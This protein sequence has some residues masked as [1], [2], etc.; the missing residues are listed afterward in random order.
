MQN[1]K[2]YIT[3]CPRDAMQGIT[4]FIPTESKIAYLNKLMEVGFDRLDFGSFVSPKAI[5]QLR[6]TVEVLS[7]LNTNSNTKLLAIVANSRGAEDASKFET[8]RYLGFPFSVSETFQK[9][10]TNTS[11]TESYDTVMR[12]LEITAKSGQTPLVY[13]SMAF[14]NPYQDLWNADVV[15]KWVEKLAQAGV[16]EFALADTVGMA[17]PEDIT[18]LMHSVLSEFP[19]LQIGAHLHCHPGNWKKKVDAAFYAGCRHFD[20]AIK[21]FGGCPMAEDELVGNLATE[22]LIQY[23]LEKNV[24]TQINE[25]RF[26]EALSASSDVFLA[27]H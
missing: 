19:Q 9:R 6:D 21:G 5:P 26:N 16:K 13:I 17:K 7:K 3:E 8:I 11:I 24:E 25:M 23:L 18:Y 4:E 27:Y 1:N 12:I 14:G 20:T 15:I 2:V 22:N 10:N